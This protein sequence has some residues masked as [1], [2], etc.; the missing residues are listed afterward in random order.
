MLGQGQ[1][2]AAIDFSRIIG[3]PLEAVI[4]AQSKSARLT[5]QFIEDAAFEKSSS[6][7][8][9][10]GSGGGAPAKKLK[11]VEFDYGQMMGN[12]GAGSSVGDKLKIKVPLLTMLPIPFI[13]VSDMTINFNVKLH[14]THTTQETNVAT[15]NDSASGEYAGTKFNCSVTDKNTY[16]DKMVIDDTYSLNVVV[17]AVQD[18][19][20][21]GMQNVLDIFSSVIQQQSSLIQQVMSESISAQSK[22]IEAQM[23]SNSG[24]GSA[25]ATT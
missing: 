25:A 3:G 16:Q 8:G 7:A 1:E 22:E 18:Q 14:T 9:G 12:L 15:T 2:I 5:T 10:T 6:T 24:A 23:K 20:P 19:M 4:E 13:R 11:V 17:H 21:G